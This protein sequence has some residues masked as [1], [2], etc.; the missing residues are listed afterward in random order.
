MLRKFL[1]ARE[2]NF[3]AILAIASVPLMAAVVGIVDF[4]SVNNKAT[5]LQDA[6]D[7]AA[8]AV[9]T[10]Y[11][12][13]M[14]ANELEDMGREFFNSNVSALYTNPDEFDYVAPEDDF[15]AEALSAGLDDFITVRSSV[16]HQGMLGSQN[17]KARRQSVVRIS[18]G[19]PACILALDRHAL[20]SIKIQGSTKINMKG[21]LIAANS[22]SSEAISRGGSAEISA[23]CVTTVGGTSGLEGISYAQLECP[24]PLEYQ[25]PTRDPLANVTPPDPTGCISAPNAKTK[26]LSP[27]TYCSET[28][29]GEV[30]LEPGSYILRGGEVK[31]GGNGFLIGHGVTIFLLEGAKFAI[32]ANQIVQLS[33]PES[34]DYAGITIYQARGNTSPLMVDGGVGSEITGFVYAPSA[35]VFHAGNSTTT[36]EGKC[37][38]IVGNTIEMTG[39]SSVSLNCEGELG[40]RSI[41]AGRRMTIVR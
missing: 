23:K 37:L 17:W 40:G 30:T 22:D 8:L 1:S 35:H 3:A 32:S 9:A 6:L 11:Y 5:K 21:C 13:G 39:N 10:K 18:P 28:I 20:S 38:R 19:E 24:Q 16:A 41:M 33:P 7:T 4:V 26:T 15:S 36:T 14:S 29:S 2:G 27:G 25:Y 34:G 12:S 31:L